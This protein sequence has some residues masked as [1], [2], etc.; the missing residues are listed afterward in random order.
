MS[1]MEYKFSELF[2]WQSGKPVVL[3]DGE[4]PVYGSNGIVGYTHL[5]KFKN[6][7]ILGRVGAYCGSVEYCSKEFNATDNTLVTTCDESKILYQ[8]AFYLLN[9]YKLNKYAGGSAQPLITQGVLKHL[10]CDIP[11]IETQSQITNILLSYDNLIENNN[12]RIK[13]LEQMIEE[14]YKEWFVRYRIHFA[15]L[16]FKKNTPN[17]W[18]Y[19]RID[20][21]FLTSSGGTPARNRAE[22]YK[23][24]TIPWVKTGELLDSIIFET[25]EHITEE[26]IK[27]SAA[28]IIE[29]YSLL[30]SMYAGV[31]KLGINSI[32]MTCSQATCVIKPISYCSVYYLFSWLKLNKVYLENISS[33]AAQ[34]NISQ[35]IIKK[36]RFLC[37]TKEIIRAYDQMVVPMWDEILFLKKKNKLLEQ[38]RDLLLPRLMSGKLEVK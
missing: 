36:I 12:K 33:G 7:I 34:Q 13:I 9:Q 21:M 26:A 29:P 4:I 19:R 5:A 24:G 14:L 11:N 25:E 6:K 3:N 1:N 32:E 27:N 35:E 10:K 23:N 15:K 17:G 38:Q 20:E 22:Y 30:C 16:T 18:E 8:Y 37:P 2:S 28:K 31:G